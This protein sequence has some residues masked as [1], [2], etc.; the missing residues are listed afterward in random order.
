MDVTVT[1]KIQ[2]IPSDEDA[3]S[4]IDT[5][6]IYTKAC[7]YVSDYI[8]RTHNLKQYSINEALYYD[9]RQLFGLKSQMAQSVIKTV[10]AR[11]RT[12]RSNRNKWI[13]PSF[14]AYDMNMIWYGTVITRL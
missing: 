13:K 6:H 3:E 12:I 7:N 11:Y 2:L 8:F 4:L 1:A 14:H 9:L 10:L 5:S